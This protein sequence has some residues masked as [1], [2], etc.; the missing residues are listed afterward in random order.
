MKM[1][2]TILATTLLAVTPAIAQDRMMTDFDTDADSMLNETEFGEAEGNRR[3]MDYD[4]DQSGDVS[5]EEFRAG[6]MRRYDANRDMSIDE[7][8]YARFDEDMRMIDEDA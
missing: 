6:E 4:A 8:E 7:D 5:E 2:A 1:S 3:F